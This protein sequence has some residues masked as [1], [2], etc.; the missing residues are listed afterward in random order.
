LIFIAALRKGLDIYCEK[1]LAYDIR[2]GRAKV[3]DEAKKTR[4]DR[5]DRFSASSKQKFSRMC[6]NTSGK[7]TLDASCKLTLKS[8]TTLP[9]VSKEVHSQDP[10]AHT[11][12][13]PV[14]RPQPR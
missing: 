11:G 6:A 1:P 10:P 12:L 3:V 7:T 9:V 2:E 14:V 8:T 13:E 5:A 4:T